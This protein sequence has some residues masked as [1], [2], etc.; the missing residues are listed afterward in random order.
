MSAPDPVVLGQAGRAVGGLDHVEALLGQHVGQCLAVGLLVLDDQHPGHRLIS[1]G[2]WSAP[3]TLVRLADLAAWAGRRSGRWAGILMV[4]VEPCP[5]WLQT[6]T[7]PPWFA[8]T[9]LTIDRPEAGAAVGAAA[10]VVDPVEALEDPLDLGRR[11]ADAVVG[12]GD[13][14]VVVVAARLD[15]RGD[16]HPGAGVGVDDGVLD[17]VADGDAELAGAAE[18]LG[19]GGRRRWSA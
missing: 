1:W 5:G 11:D 12:D 8:A 14:D 16:D 2:C 6:E 9:C 3:S 7:S 18:H 4:K 13:L 17:Q 15:V 19:A 10:R